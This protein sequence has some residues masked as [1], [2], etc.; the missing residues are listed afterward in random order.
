M[1]RIAYFVDVDLHLQM[2]EAVM[3]RNFDASDFGSFGAESR[4]VEELMMMLIETF[5]Y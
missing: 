2:V 1:V 5:V 4:M 3:H